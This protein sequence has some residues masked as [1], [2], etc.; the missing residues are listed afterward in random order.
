MGRPDNDLYRPHTAT[1]FG[2]SPVSFYGRFNIGE[3]EIL[4]VKIRLGENCRLFDAKICILMFL[5]G[6]LTKWSVHS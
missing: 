4:Q 1:F 2:G 5:G 6:S 3:A